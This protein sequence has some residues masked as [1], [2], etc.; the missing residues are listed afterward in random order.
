MDMIIT[1]MGANEIINQEGIGREE[2]QAPERA[3]VDTY[4]YH[5][6]METEKWSLDLEIKRSFAN[7]G[8]NLGEN[9]II[10]LGQKSDYI[11]LRRE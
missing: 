6:R 3:L 9:L 7:L 4:G 11:E 10:R 2:K 8:E 5:R 1:S